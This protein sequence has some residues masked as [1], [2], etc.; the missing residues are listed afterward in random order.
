MSEIWLHPFK[1]GILSIL[2][3]HFDDS[4]VKRFIL[5]FETEIYNPRESIHVWR[6]KKDN[7][8]ILEVRYRTGEVI[9]EY[10]CDVYSWESRKATEHHLLQYITDKVK[11]GKFGQDWIEMGSKLGVSDVIKSGKFETKEAHE[12]QNK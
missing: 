7:N 6:Q 1:E 3:K 8:L 12:T 9:S 11:A 10:I 5:N 4:I 2:R